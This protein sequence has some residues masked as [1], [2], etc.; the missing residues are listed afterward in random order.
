MKDKGT[1]KGKC[2]LCGKKMDEKH[3]MEKEHTPHGMIED[4]KRR[5]WISLI[6]TIP[7]LLLSPLTPELF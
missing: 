5:F 3:R 7:I 4:Y 1:E 6:L 2:I